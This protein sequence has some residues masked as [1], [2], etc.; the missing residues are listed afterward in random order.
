MTQKNM[1]IAGKRIDA[2]TV[3]TY[4]FFSPAEEEL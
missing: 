2:E 3:K 4:S 1:W